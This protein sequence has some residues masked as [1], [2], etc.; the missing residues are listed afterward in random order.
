V[1]YEEAVAIPEARRTS[2]QQRIVVEHEYA[3]ARRPVQ[4][5]AP[6]IAVNAEDP[7]L[8]ESY[9]RFLVALAHMEDAAGPYD[10]KVA[11][12]EDY[13]HFVT[14]KALPA[15]K[16]DRVNHWVDLYFKEIGLSWTVA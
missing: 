2:A 1:T 14:F 3:M 16:R 9:E 15:E 6:A 10:P 13:M 5:Q 11:K 8:F 4:A 7:A 12:H